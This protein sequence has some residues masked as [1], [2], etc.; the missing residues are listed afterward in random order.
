MNNLKQEKVNVVNVLDC[1][2]KN[3]EECKTLYANLLI[4]R[5]LQ[6]ILLIDSNAYDDLEIFTGIDE[7]NN[8]IFNSINYTKTLSGKILFRNI[9]NSPTTN[10][11]TLKTHQK[12]LKNLVKNKQLFTQ[13]EEKVRQSFT[14]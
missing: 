13:I 12:I 7:I 1:T 8:S 6:I 9:L 5:I 10:I 11:S 4:T 14:T 3:K 2:L